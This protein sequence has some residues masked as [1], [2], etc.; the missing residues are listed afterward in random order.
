MAAGF[1]NVISTGQISITYTY[2]QLSVLRRWIEGDASLDNAVRGFMD[3]NSIALALWPFWFEFAEKI[4]ADPDYPE[5]EF[6]DAAMELLRDV[7]SFQAR[8]TPE[9]RREFWSDV[10][11]GYCSACGRE[12]PDGEQC[13]CMNDE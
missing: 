1:M 9:K 3:A 6:P 2:F 7:R 4:K 8:L 11:A 13:H 10:M 12:T 5:K